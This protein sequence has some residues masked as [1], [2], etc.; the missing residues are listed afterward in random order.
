MDASLDDFFSEVNAAEDAE[1]EAASA[2]AAAPAPKR[3]R[4]AAAAGPVVGVAVAS[5]KPVI[6]CLAPSLEEDRAYAAAHRA[7]TSG[8]SVANS[9]DAAKA[10][11]AAG[12]AGAAYA[13]SHLARGGVQGTLSSAAALMPGSNSVSMNPFLSGGVME[14]PEGVLLDNFA[15]QQSAYNYEANRTRNA[16]VIE[17]EAGQRPATLAPSAARVVASSAA[18]AAATGGGGGGGGGGGAAAAAAATAA[19]KKKKILMRGGGKTWEDKS[20]EDWPENDFRLFCGDLGNE[21]TDEVLAA[22]FRQYASFARARVV[23]DKHNGKSKG[24]GFVSFTD[25]YDSLRALREM[26]KKYIGNR[27]VKLSKSNWEDRKI[28]NVRA[29]EKATKKRKKQ[30]GLD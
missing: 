29:K 19:P 23:R 9:L 13:A 21:V 14:A 18:S 25:P 11:A 4:V 7:S 24:F 5:S 22:A 17:A 2:A 10:L 15:R 30:Y 6:G 28:G 16:K 1:K 3:A 27:P 8:A 26:N 12:P 20:L